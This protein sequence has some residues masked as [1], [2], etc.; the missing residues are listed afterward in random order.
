MVISM[1]MLF[2]W[3]TLVVV[4]TIFPF[5]FFLSILVGIVGYWSL[6]L[7]LPT[8]F[9]NNNWYCYFIGIVIS[10]L[11]LF[12]W[13]CYFIGIVISFLLLFQLVL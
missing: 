8:T 6:S 2:H 13:C 4:F 3:N 1:V 5:L 11:G 12:Y 9:N 7:A 10:F